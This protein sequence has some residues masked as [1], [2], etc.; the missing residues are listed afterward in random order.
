MVHLSINI[1]LAKRE[2]STAHQ[3]IHMN[4]SVVV[5]GTAGLAAYLA[6][7]LGRPRVSSGG[8]YSAKEDRYGGVEIE[9]FDSAAA[10]STERFADALRI[11]VDSWSAAGKGGLWLRI[12]LACAG[13]AGAAA[14]NGFAFHHAQP[15]YLLMTRWL[16]P[17]PSPLP[18]YGFTQIGVGGVVLN[19]RDEVLMVQE[20][21]SPMARYQGTWKLP[22]GLAD[23]G[24]NFADTVLRE[25]M[26]ETGVKGALEG[27]VSLRH[28]HGFRFNQGDL[29]VL[30]RLR[31]SSDTI[32]LDTHELLDARWMSAAKIGALV[33][34]DPKA[35]LDGKVSENNYKMICNA[36]HGRMII[37]EEMQTRGVAKAP[38][39]Y[40][41][42][43]APTASL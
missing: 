37:G 28:G 18:S 40:T 32:T 2:A 20:R 19:A 3:T 1:G 27:V 23:P 15:G 8:F 35:S 29:Y 39:L 38:M 17:T 4:P 5:A 36:L 9:V 41:A 12:P 22:G 11:S 30:V 43:T 25:V 16:L 42:S 26:E 31:A 10:I 6:F 33:E 21:V 34:R 14:A 24:E 7:K 13:L